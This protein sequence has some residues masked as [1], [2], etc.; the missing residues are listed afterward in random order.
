MV[1]TVRTF[2]RDTWAEI[3][4]KSIKENIKAISAL[5]EGKDTKIMAVVK[6]DGYGHGAVKVAEAALEAGAKHLG[7]ALLD[8]ALQ[9]RNAGI[10]APIL[11]L[12]RTRPEDAVIAQANQIKLTVFQL[13]WLR[14]AEEALKAT[15]PSPLTIHL[16]FDTGMGR[17]GI[18]EKAEAEAIAVYLKKRDLFRCEGL[19][20]HFATADEQELHYYH[21]QYQ[22]FEAVLAWMRACDLEIPLIHCGNSAAGIRFPER[23]FNMFRLGI[24]MYGLSPSPE[25]TPNLPIRLKPAF[26]LKSR[27]VHVKRL[28][29][30]EAISYGATYRTSEDEWIGTIPIGYGD[31]WIRANSTKGGYVLINGKK[32]PFVGRICMDQCMVR[33]PEEVKVGT[34]VTL[35]GIDGA[36]R[37]TMDEVASRLETINYE[38]PCIIN[39]RVPR[40]YLNEE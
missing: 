20:T 16:K 18:R 6:A 25:M 19:Y 14:E 27:L 12:G 15:S 40:I 8:E 24:S 2:Y 11:V 35:I 5:Y 13:D 32:A 1:E 36:E 9:L 17:V 31:G 28:P 10:A 38:I 7:V 30:G 33:L 23:N 37:I 29:Q 39:Q 34:V 3:N 4:L 21:E 22:R 26:T